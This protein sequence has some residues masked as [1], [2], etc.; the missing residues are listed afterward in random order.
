MPALPVVL[1]VVTGTWWATTSPGDLALLQPYAE[2]CNYERLMRALSVEPAPPE[3]F[4]FVVLGDSR[5]NLPVASKVFEQAIAEKPIMIFHTGDL[6][7]GGTVKEY[8]ENY[9][10]LVDLA[11]PVPVF[12]VPGNHERGSRHDFAAFKALYGDVQFS[13]DY[14]ACRFVGLNVSEKTCVTRADLEFLEKELSKPGV[15]YKFVFFHV[16]PTYFEREVGIN[17]PRGFEWNADEVRS[18]LAK[19]QVTEVFMAHVHG[20]A[21]AVIDSVRYTLTA[22]AGAPFD[23]RLPI[24]N[25]IFHYMVVHVMPDRVTQ[26]LVY[27]D[28]TT[29]TWVRRQV[30]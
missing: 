24:K 9:L 14:G 11:H 1:I 21:T 15:K 10:P 6:V 30:Y 2:R 16:P 27:M 22:G 8:L 12:A 18:I 19:H 17:D 4:S 20:Y 3:L 29:R 23:H 25:R 7:R 5:N 13:F 26:E 28:M